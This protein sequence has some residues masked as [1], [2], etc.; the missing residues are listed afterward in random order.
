MSCQFDII[1]RLLNYFVKIYL[2]IGGITMPLGRSRLRRSGMGLPDQSSHFDRTRLET[3]KLQSDNSQASDISPEVKKFVGGMVSFYGSIANG[4]A[5]KM[6][7]NSVQSQGQPVKE[8]TGATG[9]IGFKGE[10]D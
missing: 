5:N 9:M 6:K 10:E 1:D 7:S 2:L 4:V 3:Q 8:V